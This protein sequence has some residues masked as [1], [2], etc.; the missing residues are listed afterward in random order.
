MLGEILTTDKK[1]ILCEFLSDEFRIEE[2]QQ[3]ILYF[4]LNENIRSGE[5]E[6]NR[7]ILKK[8]DSN[9]FIIY[10]D[11]IFPT[12]MHREISCCAA[13]TLQELLSAMADA[14]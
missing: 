9:N 1:A 3:D 7:Q 6:G 14:N 12:D 13:F 8:L 4:M 2:A 5:Y 11:D 10:T